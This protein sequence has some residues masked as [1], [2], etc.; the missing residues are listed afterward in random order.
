MSADLEVRFV[1][2]GVAVAGLVLVWAISCPFVVPSTL[3]DWVEGWSLFILRWER[4]GPMKVGI[5]P[6]SVMNCWLC[7]FLCLSLLFWCHI[8]RSWSIRQCKEQAFYNVNNGIT[9]PASDDRMIQ[10]D[11]IQNSNAQ[12]KRIPIFRSAH[13]VLNEVRCV[14]L[15]LLSPL[16][17]WSPC[18][19]WMDGCGFET[20]WMWLTKCGKSILEFGRSE[21]DAGYQDGEY[22]NERPYVFRFA[23]P[24]T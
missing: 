20:I 15:Y 5:H 6:V 1:F 7:P 21:W 2:Y 10:R 4:I 16:V 8:V 18:V 23:P 11:P 13:A 22:F 19:L 12:F 14:D 3:P 24:K 17:C 9:P